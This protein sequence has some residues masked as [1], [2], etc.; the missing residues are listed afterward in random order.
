LMR[1]GR[2]EGAERRRLG[3]LNNSGN[4]GKSMKMESSQ[5]TERNS[6]LGTGL[7]TVLA[8]GTI[9]ATADMEDAEVIFEMEKGPRMRPPAPPPQPKYRSRKY[10]VDLFGRR[11]SKSSCKNARGTGTKNR[12]LPRVGMV[13]RIAE[14]LQLPD[15]RQDQRTTIWT[16]GRQSCCMM[17]TRTHSKNWTTWRRI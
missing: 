9:T 10:C 12:L 14:V 6:I 7:R 8:K 16:T 3:L 11:G 17:S 5:G 2:L 4:Q 15:E 1:V 13:A